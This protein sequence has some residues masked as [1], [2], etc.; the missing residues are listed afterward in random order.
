VEHIRQLKTLEPLG[1]VG[2]IIGRAIYEGKVS[3]REV[4]AAIGEISSEGF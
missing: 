1:V 3:L 2:C 4:L